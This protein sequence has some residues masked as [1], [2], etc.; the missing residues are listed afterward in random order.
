MSDMILI[1]NHFWKQPGTI[2]RH[3]AGET[4]D[5][6]WNNHLRRKSKSGGE[7]ETFGAGVGKCLLDSIS[8]LLPM[9]S[10]MTENKTQTN[11]EC[12]QTLP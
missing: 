8:E 3:F 2:R 9:K 7:W 6:E 10:S 1:V 12:S 5:E 4:L 11:S